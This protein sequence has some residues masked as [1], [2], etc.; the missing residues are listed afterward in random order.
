MSKAEKIAENIKICQSFSEKKMQKMSQ[1]FLARQ[2]KIKAVALKLFISKGYEDTSLKE[3]IKKSGG[4]FSDI[5][6]T[7]KNKQGLFLSV[8]DDVIE[9]T[10]AE[11]SKILNQNMPLRETL[12]A[13]SFVLIST[14]TSRKNLALVKVVYS[15]LY[16]P[17]NHILI[18]HFRQHKYKIP[19]YVLAD[20]FQ[21]CPSPLCEDAQKYAELFLILLRGKC[22]EGVFL[23]NKPLITNKEKL[24]EYAKFA[25]DFFLKALK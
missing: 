20:Y 11:Y 6:T 4:S 8:I 13:F 25:I 17:Q 7:Y 15:Q 16:K 3:I 10:R 18:E 2:K 19:E 1:K 24:E 21:K 12:L 22:F 9:K 23:S 5:Y 14:L